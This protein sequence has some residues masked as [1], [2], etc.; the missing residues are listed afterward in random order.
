[1]AGGTDAFECSSHHITHSFPVS[2]PLQGLSTP[3]TGSSSLFT[4]HNRS[5]LLTLD[6][7]DLGATGDVHD[8]TSTEMKACMEANSIQ[9]D[10]QFQVL[11]DPEK[12]I[13]GV[14]I[15]ASGTVFSPLTD[16]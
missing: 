12:T 4:D 7:S 2:V 10:H 1:M 6:Q 9:G 11:L 13:S 15:G 3:P 5:P 14:T 8:A 16:D